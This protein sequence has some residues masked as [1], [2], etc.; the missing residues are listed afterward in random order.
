MTS[1]RVDR[2]CRLHVTPREPFHVFESQ[3]VTSPAVLELQRSETGQA[4]LFVHAA[5]VV[6]Q[7]EQRAQPSVGHGHMAAVVRMGHA[8]TLRN[9]EVNDKDSMV[10]IHFTMEAL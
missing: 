7:Y 9:T 1:E 6:S 5:Q 3:R 4:G 2:T 8:R 10:K